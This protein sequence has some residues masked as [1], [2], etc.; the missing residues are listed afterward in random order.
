MLDK[1]TYLKDHIYYKSYYLVKG[2]LPRYLSA[3][4]HRYKLK[5]E[6]VNRYYSM[7]WRMNNKIK[8]L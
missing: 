6:F 1:I 8:I 2:G 3:I 4:S 5:I 7:V